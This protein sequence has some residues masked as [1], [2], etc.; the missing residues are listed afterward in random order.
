MPLIH[1]TGEAHVPLLEQQ[2]TE[3]F[4]W[5]SGWGPPPATAVYIT[6]LQAQDAQEQVWLTWELAGTTATPTTF[7]LEFSADGISWE[8]AERWVAPPAPSPLSYS[9]ADHLTAGMRR[10][11][12]LSIQQAGTPVFSDVLMVIRPLPEP[13]V[14]LYPNPV[15]TTLD[16]SVACAGQRPVVTLENRAGQLV[17]RILSSDPAVVR[18]TL[19]MTAMPAGM[20]LLRV[21]IGDTPYIYPVIKQ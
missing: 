12:R 21:E 18:H 5:L 10:F 9:Y 1:S 3:V 20:Y 6:R 14:S 11:Y 8:V 2:L 15:Q 19:D 16:I 4:F 17:S 13:T 7:S